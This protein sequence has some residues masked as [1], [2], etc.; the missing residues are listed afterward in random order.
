MA[1]RERSPFFKEHLR[2][3]TVAKAAS[4]PAPSAPTRATASYLAH[5]QMPLQRT[6]AVKRNKEARDWASAAAALVADAVQRLLG[7]PL[8]LDE[9]FMSA[10]LD[11]LGAAHSTVSCSGC[12]T[13]GP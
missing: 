8:C 3:I 5:E 6:A 10:G 9:A 1:G 11:S 2:G 13:I 4:V 7:R 12:R